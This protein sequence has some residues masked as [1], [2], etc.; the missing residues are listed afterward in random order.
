MKL[1]ALDTGHLLEII[2]REVK[3]AE[4]ADHEHAVAGAGINEPAVAIRPTDPVEENVD[5]RLCR[6]KGRG[7]VEGFD[8]GREVASRIKQIEHVWDC[9][10]IEPWY[11][12]ASLIEALPGVLPG[13]V[14][15]GSDD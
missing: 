14:L 13:P 11:E 3:A 8:S 7:G 5:H 6:I 1:P 10:G 4:S 12:A 2:G 15:L 9:L